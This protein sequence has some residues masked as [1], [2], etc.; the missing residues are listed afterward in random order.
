MT[1]LTVR[2]SG[3]HLARVYS[4]DARSMT[5]SASFDEIS[6]D[7][8]ISWGVVTN[9]AET[10][11]GKSMVMFDVDHTSCRFRLMVD[12]EII[13]STSSEDHELDLSALHTINLECGEGVCRGFI[14]I[15]EDED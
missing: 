10:S 3:F 15:G 6:D 12:G 9:C 7:Y 13:E 14:S 2:G 5:S 8:D 1:D 4:K 11:D